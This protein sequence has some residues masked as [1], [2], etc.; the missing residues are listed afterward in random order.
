[1]REIIPLDLKLVSSF[2]HRSK[3]NSFLRRIASKSPFTIDGLAFLY[4]TDEMDEIPYLYFP[5]YSLVRF[6]SQTV[7]AEFR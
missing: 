1:M 6:K 7:E 2:H 5:D 3:F 4:I